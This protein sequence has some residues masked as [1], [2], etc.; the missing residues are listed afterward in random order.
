MLLPAPLHKGTCLGHTPAATQL[1]RTAGPVLPAVFKCHMW[2]YEAPCCSP[3]KI[4]W[5]NVLPSR[6]GVLLPD[7]DPSVT[8]ALL[9][10]GSPDAPACPGLKATS[11]PRKGE[12]ST[13]TRRDAAVRAC[14]D[15]W[16]PTHA[17]LL[18]PCKACTAWHMLLPTLHRRAQSNTT[19]IGGGQ[20]P[21]VGLHSESSSI[22]GSRP[23]APGS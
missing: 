6:L 4:S 10:W 16:L 13:C 18:L 8:S 9:W 22:S 3:E 21:A 12:S 5:A 17:P 1:L 19:H 14:Y 7:P 15:S 23:S 2:Q 11:P 20:T